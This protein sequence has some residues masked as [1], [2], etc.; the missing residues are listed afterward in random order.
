[1]HSNANSRLDNPRL[2]FGRAVVPPDLIRLVSQ[3]I[4]NRNN[5]W[6]LCVIDSLCAMDGAETTS[7]SNADIAAYMACSTNHASS[8]ISELRDAEII[9]VQNVPTANGYQRI[10][11]INWTRMSYIVPRHKGGA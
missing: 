11:S 4:I 6:L 9:H 5:A 3:G 8:M 7:A 1:M 2:K 10:L